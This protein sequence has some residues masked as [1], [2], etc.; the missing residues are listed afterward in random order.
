MYVL[1][2]RRRR[3]LMN[4]RN[5]CQ[6][7]TIV[8]QDSESIQS[9]IKA[10]TEKL[11]PMKTLDKQ[12]QE[13]LKRRPCNVTLKQHFI[14]CSCLS[15][16]GPTHVDNF[17]LN[18][19][20]VLIFNNIPA[21][22]VFLPGSSFTV[23]VNVLAHSLTHSLQHLLKYQVHMHLQKNSIINAHT[24][25]RWFFIQIVLSKIKKLPIKQGV[26]IK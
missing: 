26:K 7:L 1:T 20:S 15:E 21:H 12:S 3:V 23:S 13:A 25:F 14:T 16:L 24:T 19:P 6:P 2:L 10:P 22:I 11:S 5:H 9:H 8:A 4:Y 18:I 17:V